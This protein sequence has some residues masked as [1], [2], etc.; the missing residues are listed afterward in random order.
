MKSTTGKF[1]RPIHISCAELIE[2]TGK[3]RYDI[4]RVFELSDRSGIM[5][6][7]EH[8]SEFSA[9]IL[10]T[11]TGLPAGVQVDSVSVDTSTINFGPAIALT[12]VTPEETEEIE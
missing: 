11:L 8:M 4:Y 5:R 7:A 6:I 10:N 9:A 12:P 1:D 2:M 3:R